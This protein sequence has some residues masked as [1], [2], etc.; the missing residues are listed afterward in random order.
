MGQGSFGR[1][2]SHN[3]V[4]Q[5]RVRE[6]FLIF[7]SIAAIHTVRIWRDPHYANFFAHARSDGGL[8]L[9]LNFGVP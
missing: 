6:S 7:G 8:D 5:A 4:N 1:L 9:G 2:R 3:L